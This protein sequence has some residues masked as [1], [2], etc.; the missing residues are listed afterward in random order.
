[1]SID[2]ESLLSKPAT[3]VEPPARF[4]QGHYDLMVVGKSQGVSQQKK[5]PYLEFEFKV[6]APRED[7]DSEAYAKIKNPAERTLKAQFYI[8][9]ES[10][11]RLVQFCEACGVTREGKTVAQ[12]V[13][14][15][16][17]ASVVGQITEELEDVSKKPAGTE[18]RIFTRLGKFQ[19]A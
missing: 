19:K 8:T 9:D 6:I 15:T 3:E 2:F 13:E 16:M 17:N 10:L 18:P 12:M 5:T 11:D 1:M 7:V 14:E 4:P